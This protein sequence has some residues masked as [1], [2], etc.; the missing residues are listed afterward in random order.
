MKS[1]SITKESLVTALFQLM[2]EKPFKDIKIK[3][4]IERSGVSKVSYYRNF[5]S[6]EDILNSYMLYETSK[7]HE[8]H[9][10]EEERVF[11]IHLFEHLSNFKVVFDLLYKN[12]L[13]YIFSEHVYEWCGPKEDAED[14]NAYLQ[15]AI[16]YSVFGF[17]DEWIRRGMKG[18]PE[19]LADDLI[20]DLNDFPIKINHLKF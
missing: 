2:K 7:F 16:A 5:K 8:L 9:N 3:E 14:S 20:K 18:S 11:L 1:N 15:S 6:K 19:E 13:S 4:I 10:G 17:L 12:H